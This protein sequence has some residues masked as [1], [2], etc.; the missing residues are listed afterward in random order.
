MKI[1]FSNGTCIHLWGEESI[2]ITIKDTKL[3]YTRPDGTKSAISFPKQWQILPDPLSEQ[4]IL[5]NSSLRDKS[6]TSSSSNV[7]APQLNDPG[8]ESPPSLKSTGPTEEKS[9]KSLLDFMNE[10]S[11]L[12]ERMKNL[13][14]DHGSLKTIIRISKP[15]LKIK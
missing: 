3:C 11:N 12:E 9:Q 14:C 1:K 8:E 7:H 15:I 2:D 13:N 5:R 6:P 4:R 10:I